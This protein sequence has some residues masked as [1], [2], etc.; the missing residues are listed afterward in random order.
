MA[1]FRVLILF[2]LPTVLLGQTFRARQAHYND[3]MGE[4]DGGS[5]EVLPGC[6]WY[7]GGFVSDFKASSVLKASKGISYAAK[8]AH[9]F[10]IST[11]WV[12]GQVDYGV[13]ETLEYILDMNSFQGPHEL[14]ITR[15]ILANGYKK[16]RKQWEE[17]SRVRR[18]KMYVDDQPYGILELLDSFEFQTIDIGKIMLPQE[19]IMTI[20]FEIVA[21]YSGTKFKDTAISELLFDGVGVH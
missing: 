10:D 11:A 9:D 14:G 3:F 17:N 12:E 4:I 6:S 1:T 7:C 21:V 8:N 20:R 19:K 5:L 16:S 13:G 18:M 15:I 2:F